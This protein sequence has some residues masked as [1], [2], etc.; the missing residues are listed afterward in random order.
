M[1]QTK[2]KS[3]TAGKSAL[4]QHQTGAT[5][6]GILMGVIS[7]LFLVLVFRYRL[8]AFA[9]DP[10]KEQLFRGV[11]L[12]YFNGMLFHIVPRLAK[13]LNAQEFMIQ[14]NQSAIDKVWPEYVLM[15]TSAFLVLYMG[16]AVI[17]GVM[18]EVRRY[19]SGPEFD[20][21]TQPAQDWSSVFAGYFI[22]LFSS[23]VYWQMRLLRLGR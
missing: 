17:V 14:G 12:V 1:A 5:L 11:M 15:V 7:I 21:L 22:T 8:N 9:I 19:G 23:T 6:M 16:E 4:P 10:W 3:G 13:W 18:A 20:A 2:M